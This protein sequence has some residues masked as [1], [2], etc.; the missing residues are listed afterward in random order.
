MIKVFL[1]AL[2]YGVLIEIAQ[3]VFTVSRKGDVLDVLA[4][5]TGSVTAAFLLRLYDTTFRKEKIK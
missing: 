3:T 2:F 1:A 5:T 4:N